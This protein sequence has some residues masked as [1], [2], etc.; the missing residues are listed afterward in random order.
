VTRLTTSEIAE[1]V[2][3][4]DEA[5]RLYGIDDTFEFMAQVRGL[6]GEHYED[7]PLH[8]EVLETVRMCSSRGHRIAIVSSTP[9]LML[10]HIVQRHQLEP[11]IDVLLG[12][13]DVQEQKPY[14]EIVFKALD[15][16]GGIVEQALIVGDAD[17]DIQA[18]HNAGV[19]TVVHYPPPNHEFYTL[20]FLKS[21]KPDFIIER[22]AQLLD[23]VG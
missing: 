18:G 1:R 17:K 5:S 20:E 23:I 22:F 10:V 19:K 3:G 15:K 12:R 11:Y 21:F 2:F 13:E 7:A 9:R 16:L 8:A 14:P 4:N 6:V